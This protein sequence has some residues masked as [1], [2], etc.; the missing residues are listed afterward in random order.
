MQGVPKG[1]GGSRRPGDSSCA[2]VSCLASSPWPRQCSRSCQESWPWQECVAVQP[3]MQ[4]CVGLVVVVQSTGSLWAAGTAAPAAPLGLLWLWGLSLSRQSLCGTWRA[5]LQGK[6][7]QWLPGNGLSSSH[8]KIWHCY[9]LNYFSD[10]TLDQSSKN[11]KFC[12]S[13][14][15]LLFLIFFFTI[16]LTFL[17]LLLSFPWVLYFLNY[18][19]NY[20]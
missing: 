8:G 16:H 5:K 20:F 18:L 9:E 1:R 15:P 10:Y 11:K 2:A 12:I 3:W 19:I 14:V 13:S 4:F 7:A 17:K 6:G